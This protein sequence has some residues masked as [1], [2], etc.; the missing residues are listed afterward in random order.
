MQET[1]E[2]NALFTLIDDPDEEVYT[3][4]SSKII[5]YGKGIIPNLEN[6]WETTV[7]AEVQERVEMLKVNVSEKKETELFS[8]CILLCD[9]KEHLTETK[10]AGC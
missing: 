4:V 5:G 9:S 7:S 10:K 3:T 2:L 6:L 8:V 1:K